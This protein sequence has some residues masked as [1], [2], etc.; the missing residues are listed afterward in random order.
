MP[1]GWTQLK[2]VAPDRGEN[3]PEEALS[4]SYTEPAFAI[5]NSPPL[6][7][8]SARVQDRDVQIDIDVS[9]RISALKKV[10]YSIDYG[11][12][13]FTIAAADGCIRRSSRTGPVHLIQPVRRR[14]R[15][16]RAGVGCAGQY[17]HPADHHSD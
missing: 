4:S 2:L 7:E 13:E 15:D 5:D 14:A 9:D 11:D 3:P 16:R 10:Q 6:V 1:E 8:I 17:R 12:E